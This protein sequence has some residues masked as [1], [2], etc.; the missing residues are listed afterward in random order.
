MISASHPY[1]LSYNEAWQVVRVSELKGM[2]SHMCPGFLVHLIA[3]LQSQE[4]QVLIPLFYVYCLC[5][6]L[7]FYIT[8]LPAIW[9]PT[10]HAHKR[11]ICLCLLVYHWKAL[12]KPDVPIKISSAQ[13]GRGMEIELVMGR[14]QY[15]TLIKEW[16]NGGRCVNGRIIVRQQWHTGSEPMN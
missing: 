8:L 6:L 10:V 2:M 4:T 9:G 11:P 7:T 14:Q 16:Q 1:P 3:L 12:V 15:V 5:W 13:R